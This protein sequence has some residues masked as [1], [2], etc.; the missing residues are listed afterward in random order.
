MFHR[1][2]KK[3]LTVNRFIK[4]GI[5][6]QTSYDI[7]TLVELGLLIERWKGSVRRAKRVPQKK[8]NVAH[9]KLSASLRKLIKKTI[10]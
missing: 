7:C 9:G 2:F 6:R 8:E 3:A 4:I 1:Y 10:Y 5:P